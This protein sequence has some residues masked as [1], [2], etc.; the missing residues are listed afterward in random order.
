MLCDGWRY[1]T[2]KNINKLKYIFCVV[3]FGWNS[4]WAAVL[5]VCCGLSVR[6]RAS[7]RRECCDLLLN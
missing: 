7:E 1:F 6:A 5:I 4:Q 3:C 2:S